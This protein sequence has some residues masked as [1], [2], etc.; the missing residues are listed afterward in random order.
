MKTYRMIIRY[1]QFKDQKPLK[2]TLTSR[3]ICDPYYH[4]EV[5]DFAGIENVII[6]ATGYTG[7]GGLR[8]IVK[9]RSRTSME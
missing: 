7:S 2:V 5:G 4:F 9:F 6:S 3:F 1:W 8:F